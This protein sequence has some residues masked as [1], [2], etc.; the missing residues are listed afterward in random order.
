M[1][2]SLFQF[3]EGP[4]D[5]SSGTQGADLSSIFSFCR[6]MVSPC[7]SLWC[8]MDVRKNTLRKIRNVRVSF[9]DSSPSLWAHPTPLFEAETFFYMR[10]L[11]LPVR[12]HK[13][14][15]SRLGCP[16]SGE[17]GEFEALTYCRRLNGARGPFSREP[18]E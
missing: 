9:W 18:G 6:L 15:R 13:S 16:F 3:L 8:W 10:C 12:N 7:A 14:T 11:N 4:E 17:P 5:V 1:F 2:L